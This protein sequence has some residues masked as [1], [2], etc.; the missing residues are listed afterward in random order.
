M[1]A[2]PAAGAGLV[3]RLLF[4]RRPLVL[5]GTLGQRL[6]HDISVNSNGKTLFQPDM[7]AL[8]HE[9][10]FNLEHNSDNVTLR[11][12]HKTPSHDLRIKEHTQKQL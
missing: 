10:L 3:G 11:A 1:V 7:T 5:H 6:K 12:T 8:N 4:K 2:F 9:T